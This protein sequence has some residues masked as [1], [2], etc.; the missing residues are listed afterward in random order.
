MGVDDA[1][2]PSS[3]N[4]FKKGFFVSVSGV[5]TTDEGVDD[6]DVADVGIG[7]IVDGGG[8]ETSFLSNSWL[9]NVVGVEA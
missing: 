8:G 2:V 9:C 7:G 5:G 6:I 3:P 4:F 1:G